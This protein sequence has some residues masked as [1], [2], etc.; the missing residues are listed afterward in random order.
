MVACQSIGQLHFLGNLI[1]I[2]CNILEKE[3]V[4][5]KARVKERLSKHEGDPAV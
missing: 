4:R 5:R 2:T 1:E 3:M